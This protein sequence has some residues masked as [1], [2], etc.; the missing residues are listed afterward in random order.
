LL[1]RPVQLG[2]GVIV[3]A[4]RQKGRIMVRVDSPPENPP[5]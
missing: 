4:E 1:R 3:S 5:D 2:G